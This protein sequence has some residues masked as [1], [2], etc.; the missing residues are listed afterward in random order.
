[1]QP[2][3]H[4]R[5]P[6]PP[7]SRYITIHACL[8]FRGPAALAGARP[9]LSSRWRRS[10][11]S[12]PSTPRRSA[13]KAQ[14]SAPSTRGAPVASNAANARASHTTLVPGRR[15]A[16]AILKGSEEGEEAGRSAAAARS[17]DVNPSSWKPY[18]SQAPA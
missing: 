15:S 13:K 1:M 17:P 4:Q 10:S 3:Y 11:P 18:L 14:T 6:S 12:L 9:A 2:W 7:T 5:A 8:T 16:S